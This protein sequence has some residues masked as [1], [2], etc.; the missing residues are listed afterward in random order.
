MEH[1]IGTVQLRTSR[2]SL[3]TE[4]GKGNGDNINKKMTFKEKEVELSKNLVYW[5]YLKTAAEYY[6][7]RLDMQEVENKEVRNMERK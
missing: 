2:G 1:N 6:T 3:R 4:K 5:A 7:W